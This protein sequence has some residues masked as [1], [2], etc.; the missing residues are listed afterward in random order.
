MFY[1][2]ILFNI[3]ELIR[4]AIY[5]AFVFQIVKKN[6]LPKKLQKA[7]LETSRLFYDQV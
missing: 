2:K 4:N 7:D 3:I 5:K 1:K 6:D